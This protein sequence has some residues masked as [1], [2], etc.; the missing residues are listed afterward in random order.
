MKRR[1][2]PSSPLREFLKVLGVF[3]KVS[4]ECPHRRGHLCDLRRELIQLSGNL[5]RFDDWRFDTRGTN[6]LAHKFEGIVKLIDLPG[7]VAKAKQI[8]SGNVLEERH[9]VDGPRFGSPGLF[10][11]PLDLIFGTDSCGHS[12]NVY[13]DLQGR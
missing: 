5:G 2:L 4:R 1:L 12:D 3:L 11:D 10:D 6:D 7:E 9:P 8:E 13:R